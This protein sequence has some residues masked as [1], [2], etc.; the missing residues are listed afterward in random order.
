[1]VP[2]VW[3]GNVGDQAPVSSEESEGSEGS[4]R[5]SCC[6]YSSQHLRTL[7]RSLLPVEVT[8]VEYPGP[9]DAKQQ[10][11]LVQGTRQSEIPRC[12][13]MQCGRGEIIILSGVLRK[14]R[15]QLHGQHRLDM[16]VATTGIR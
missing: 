9:V 15:G 13:A 4:L 14:E 3:Q 7:N 8:D 10:G 12:S 5:C 1:M 6:S 11:A 16:A 2:A